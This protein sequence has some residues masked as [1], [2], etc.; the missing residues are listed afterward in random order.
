MRCG[1]RDDDT[2]DC[3][4][5]QSMCEMFIE[6]LRLTKESDQYK[7]RCYNEAKTLRGLAVFLDSEIARHL[8][9]IADRLETDA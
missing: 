9:M 3:S 2:K 5:C 1:K 7:Q 8:L 6:N 4:E